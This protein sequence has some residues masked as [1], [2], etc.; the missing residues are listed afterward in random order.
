MPTDW[1]IRLHTFSPPFAE[2]LLLRVA[3]RASR[4][5]ATALAGAVIG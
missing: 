4:F 3:A 1:P 5:A 2:V